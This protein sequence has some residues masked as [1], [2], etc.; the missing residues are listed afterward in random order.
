M[1]KNVVYLH[2]SPLSRGLEHIY[3]YIYIKGSQIAI[4][5]VY[6]LQNTLIAPCMETSNVSRYKRG[7]DN[8]GRGKAQRQSLGCNT[9]NC[10][11]SRL[12]SCPLAPD[13]HQRNDTKVCFTCKVPF[14]SGDENT[15]SLPDQRIWSFTSVS[16]GH[17]RLRHINAQAL[18][19]L[20][21]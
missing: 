1:Y 13:T 5:R 8:S 7:G 11:L 15:P 14:Q 18:K 3:I 16:I 17:R 20:L 10:R 21:G 12:L 19:E 4:N 6:V 9:K 2:P